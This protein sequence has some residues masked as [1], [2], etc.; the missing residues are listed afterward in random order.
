MIS[1]S[2]PL[3]F[4]ALA[5]LLVATAAPCYAQS[6]LTL[7]EYRSRLEALDR[8]VA[9]CQQSTNNCKPDSVGPDATITLGQ[10]TRPVTFAWLRAVLDDAAK[11][12]EAA[13][14][15]PPATPL[16]KPAVTPTAPPSPGKPKDAKQD[17]GNDDAPV[18]LVRQLPTPEIVLTL[19]EK[20][21]AARTRLHQ[22]WLWAGGR[23][24]PAPADQ[25]APSTAIPP[26]P[27]QRQTLATILARREF[28]HAVAPPSLWDKIL[29][30]LSLWVDGALGALSQAAPKSIWLWRAIEVAVLLAV[31]L[32]LVWWLI[33]LDRQGRLNA[34]SRPHP[35]AT[36]ASARDWQLWLQD[37]R[38]AA[39][40]GDWRDAIH[41]LYWASI[42]RLESTGLWAADRART[43]REYLALLGEED[44]QRPGLLALTRAFERTW[45][46]GQSAA[47]ADFRQAEQ[48][49]T[50][51]GAK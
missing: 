13:T 12:A 3:R 14:P 47:E 23:P 32:G 34:I 11:P 24:D 8:L 20:L 51:L 27:A 42:S 41:L 35:G 50:T 7:A 9:S 33:R 28:Q 6:P 10:S 46:A 37:A 31:S 49:A 18:T 26:T 4:L 30:K 21:A 17:D 44:S 40:E 16:T 25:A 22:D 29:E 43:P 2:N 39:A 5:L 36:A 45:Y 38:R 1:A 48:L 15:A 19:P